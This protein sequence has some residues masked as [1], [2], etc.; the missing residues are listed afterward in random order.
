MKKIF[1]I[2]SLLSITGVVIPCPL[3]V[4]NDTSHTVLLVESSGGD[5]AQLVNPGATAVI[6]NTEKH[7]EFY[8]FKP[9][10]PN[11]AFSRVCTVAQHTC[12]AAKRVDSTVSAIENGQLD[13]TFFAYGKASAAH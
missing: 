1:L 10:G 3:H 12:T 2:V 9:E 13:T 7:L 8:V 6:G 11:G 5:Y 4:T